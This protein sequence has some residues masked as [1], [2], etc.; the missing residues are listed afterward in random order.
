MLEPIKKLKLDFEFYN[1][2]ENLLPVF[3]FSKVKAK[4]VFVY[5]NYFGICDNQV[6][7]VSLKCSN[8][9]VDNSQAFFSKPLPLVDTIYSP[10]KFFGVPDGGY[11]YTNIKIE[12]DIE[13]DESYYRFEHL[14]GRI[15]LGAK[16]SYR[17]FIQ[18]ETSLIGQHIKIMSSLTQHLLESIDYKK[19]MEKR[20]YNF[21]YLHKALE[22]SNQL[23]PDIGSEFVPMCYPY[24]TD[25]GSILKKNLIENKV[26]AGTYWPNVSKWLQSKNTFE[27]YLQ[28]NLIP[29]PIDQRYDQYSMNR[30]INLVLDNK[31][32]NV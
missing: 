9:V 13:Q 16:K 2:D 21:N 28:N 10:R 14:L 1:I 19:A 5:N 25:R 27:V 3:D 6:D 30:I 15:D 4:D 12:D 31:N 7:E 8:L 11:L 22:N 18:N 23:K 20:C 17:A 29:I 26:Y 24:L 32:S